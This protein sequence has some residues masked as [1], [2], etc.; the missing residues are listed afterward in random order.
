MT[1]ADNSTPSRIGT[2]TS[3]SVLTSYFVLLA[4]I[5]CA[6]AEAEIVNS[7]SKQQK[8]RSM[9][10]FLSTLGEP[11]SLLKKGTGTSRAFK[12]VEKTARSLGASPLFQQAAR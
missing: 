9:G 2:R 11:G 8:R 12:M 3:N 6:E 4:G 7:T 10:S 1:S 5:A